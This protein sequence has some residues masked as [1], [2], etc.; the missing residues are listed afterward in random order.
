[1]G[2]E[3]LVQG[4]ETLRVKAD[5]LIYGHVIRGYRTTHG[6]RPDEIGLRPAYFEAHFARLS[7]RCL[8]TFKNRNH[9]ANRSKSLG[10]STEIRKRFA[11]AFRF[12][13]ASVL[14]ARFGHLQQY[15]DQMGSSGQVIRLWIAEV[16]R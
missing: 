13:V 3:S 12:G 8:F 6:R 5:E 2:D 10:Q 9:S 7:G 16:G 11:D 15:P 4:E 1:L 14:R